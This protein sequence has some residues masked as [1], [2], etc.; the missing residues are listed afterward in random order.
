[1]CRHNARGV[2]E[3]QYTALL[4]FGDLP[5]EQKISHSKLIVTLIIIFQAL[6][7][8]FNYCVELVRNRLDQGF[9]TF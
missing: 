3:H 6:V 5:I 4:A 9:A 8:K 1:M 2:P 7:L